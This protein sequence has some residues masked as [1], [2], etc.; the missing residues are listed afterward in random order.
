[1]EPGPKARRR[2]RKLA[3]A[4]PVG[5]AEDSVAALD[6]GDLPDIAA[7][8]HKRRV[9]REERLSLAGTSVPPYLYPPL[10]DPDFNA[11][12]MS[13]KEFADL[14]SD[15][16]VYDLATR[17][18]Q[19]CD[20]RDFE[21]LPHQAFVRNFLSSQT[22]YNGLL[23][24]HG[25]G[26][27][28][29]CSAISVTEEMRAYLRQI[30]IQ[31]RIII[32]ASPNVQDNFRAQLFD[33]R[34][35]EKVGD[36]WVLGTCAGDAMLR[37]VNP[38][39]MRG[40]SR[41]D[42]VRQVRRIIRKG[43]LFLGP[44]QFANYIA[45]ALGRYSEVEDPVERRRLEDESL[46]REFS[47][48][49][50]VVDEVHNIR[51]TAD[52]PTKKVGKHLTEVVRRTGGLKLLL[53]SATPMFNSPEEVVGLLNLLLLNDKR[54]PL[55]VSDV[56]DRHG[57]MK[58]DTEG[59]P[60]GREALV[61]AA[62]GYVSYVPGDNPYAF[63]MK[64]YPKTFSPEMSSRARPHPRTQLNGAPI[65][66]PME[67][68]DLYVVPTG[69]YQESVYQAIVDVGAGRV[70][71]DKGIGY[72][73]LNGP[74]QCLDIAFPV[75]EDA[76][77]ADAVGRRGLAATM[78]WKRATKRGF[79]YRQ[80]TLEKAGRF[81]SADLLPN[82]SGKL[83][84][85][86]KAATTSKGVLLVYSQYIDGGCLPIAL[87][88]E[89]RGYTR[90]IGESLFAQAPGPLLDATTLE[91]GDTAAPARYA[92]ITGDSLLSPN[93]AAE[94]V[95]ATNAGNDNGELVKVIIVS[96]AGSEGL[97]FKN[98]RQVHVVD[99]WYNLSRI[100]QIVGRAA[101]WCSHQ[102]L[103]LGQRNVEVFLYGS[104]LP[105]SEGE[106]AADVYV[107]R[108][109]ERKAMRVGAVTRVLKESATDCLLNKNVATPA[110]LRQT[111]NVELAS[112]GAAVDLQPGHMPF[113][114]TCD[115][116]ADCQ[117]KCAPEARARDEPSLATFGE[118]FISMNIGAVQRR[119]AAAFAN[120]YAY[121]RGELIGFINAQRD[122]PL[123]QI[124]AAL[125]R[126]VA[127]G[128]PPV[129]DMLGRAGSVVNLSDYYLFQPAELDN[130]VISVHDRTTPLQVRP[131]SIKVLAE[132]R[133]EE[134][135]AAPGARIARRLS[136]KLGH[137]TGTWEEG[138]DDW[139]KAIARALG[140][141]GR[142]GRVL[143][144]TPAQLLRY[145]A[146]HALDTLTAAESVA[147]YD[148]LHGKPP[149]DDAELALANAFDQ[150]SVDVNGTTVVVLADAAKASVAF[151]VASGDPR[152]LEKAT[153]VQKLAALDWFAERPQ[154][155]FA[156][157]IGVMAAD[158]KGGYVVFKIRDTQ[159]QR[160]TG[161]R[162]DQKGKVD[163]LRD[164]NR[165]LG[166][167]RYTYEG[168]ASIQSSRE[169][170]A[171]QELLLRHYDTTGE[172]GKRW[173]LSLPEELLEGAQ[174]RHRRRQIE[175]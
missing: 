149:S 57:N 9:E 106:E 93:N 157:W 119:I 152:K 140:D 174:K 138:G 99:P 156:Q 38:T 172:Q 171:D 160:T 107:Y 83:A 97:D 123:V 78:A 144:L 86:C 158:K 151:Y 19:L 56:F 132:R 41:E 6:V 70:P 62:T 65:L 136:R 46:Q 159:R 8:A 146:D 48:R 116:M 1:M 139:Y 21:L 126:A 130:P 63:P 128:A 16:G 155:A 15:K 33:P 118:G 96:E 29:T 3:I 11:D 88:L 60:V 166:A 14:E 120:G 121:T 26:T 7:D 75:D 153:P 81:L 169:L 114:S 27:G 34:K 43:Y 52:T 44:E 77:A 50:I 117:Y 67:F 58:T 66:Q 20:A 53:M 76:P 87:A 98:V 22:P 25:L 89:E 109:A 64:V 36:G 18:G 124:D 108:L 82:F 92:L 12:L 137:L 71:H 95:L 30:G 84:S 147:L 143:S 31:K 165:T 125:T 105:G 54:A 37:E 175:Q 164:L 112:G 104:A 142:L 141:T 55:R 150:R 145:G 69:R 163:V 90:A 47:D 168:T 13:R 113:T 32:V 74:L 100:D 17:A 2:A 91:R 110:A 79:S 102:A 24:F 170:C 154:P 167:E 101:R 127:P 135:A 4:T 51:D 115:F 94:V 129:R 134:E 85:I 35:L 73:A 122:Y 173:F 23:V 10:T 5:P 162:C 133:E 103:P 28:K 80:E 72:Q 111:V 45:R 59:R 39:G 148:Y 68:S 61:A 49:L 40:L 161:Y 42:V 131:L